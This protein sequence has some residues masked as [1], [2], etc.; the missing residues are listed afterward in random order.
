MAIPHSRFLVEL[1]KGSRIFSKTLDWT[2][3]ITLVTPAGTGV[4]HTNNDINLISCAD[5]AA[6]AHL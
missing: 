2:V 5:V 3:L 6:G 1:T 4:N